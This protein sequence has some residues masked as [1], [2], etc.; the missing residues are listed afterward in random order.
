MDVQDPRRAAIRRLRP[1]QQVEAP[2]AR[3]AEVTAVGLGGVLLAL[4][5]RRLGVK[6]T[7]RRPIARTPMH[8]VGP[9]DRLSLDAMPVC[10]V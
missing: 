3:F 5:Q 9:I 8:G 4:L 2:L 10:P 7:A 6:G 1:L